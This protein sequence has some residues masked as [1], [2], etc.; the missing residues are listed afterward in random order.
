MT[1]RRLPV[2]LAFSLSIVPLAAACGGDDDTTP[3][4]TT[5]TPTAAATDA[6]DSSAAEGSGGD[7]TG[8]DSG[9]SD[10][11]GES[12]LGGN[13][14]GEAVMTIGDTTIEGEI[15]QCTLVEPDVQ[16]TA[17]GETAQITVSSGGGGAVAVAV[18]GAAEFVGQGTA[19]FGEV[20]IDRGD[21]TINGTGSSPDDESPVED[22][23]IDVRIESC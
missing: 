8:T 16:F 9:G 4:T 15:V 12:A 3:A 7:T 17:Q 1:I 13:P 14:S 10:S 19:T 5:T 6:G 20:D 2:L 11:D 22:F 21:V 18:T 23:T